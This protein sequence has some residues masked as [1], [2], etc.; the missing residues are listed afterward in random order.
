MF[1]PSKGLLCWC[2]TCSQLPSDAPSVDDPVPAEI[3]S[4]ETPETLPKEPDVPSTLNFPLIVPFEWRSSPCG[5]IRG[6]ST[7]ISGLF[8]ANFSCSV[9]SCSS[10]SSGAGLLGLR[11]GGSTVFGAIC[12]AQRD[13]RTLEISLS[14]NVF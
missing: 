3:P 6:L 8:G 5:V 7:T 2:G 1:R 14:V 4:L 13:L 12:F 11:L 10:F 9:V